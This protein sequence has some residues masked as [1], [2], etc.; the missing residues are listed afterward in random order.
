[1]SNSTEA[2]IRLAES[3]RRLAIDSLASNA[4]N[5]LRAPLTGQQIATLEEEIIACDAELVILRNA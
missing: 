5:S 2:H 1:M 4:S 3:R